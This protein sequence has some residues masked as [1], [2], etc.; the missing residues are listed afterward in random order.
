MFLYS[1]HHFV[2]CS[3]STT[4]NDQFRVNTQDLWSYIIQQNGHKEQTSIN[5]SQK[6]QRIL[7]FT[8]ASALSLQTILKFIIQDGICFCGKDGLMNIGIADVWQ[9]IAIALN[10]RLV[11]GQIQYTKPPEHLCLLNKLLQLAMVPLRVLM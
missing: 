10:R 8:K 4:N 1:A 3:Q 6:A 5:N 9:G 11:F 7:V 2:Y